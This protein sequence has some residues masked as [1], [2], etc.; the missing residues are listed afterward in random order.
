MRLQLRC[1]G[2][3]LNGQEDDVDNEADGDAEIEEGVCDH[4]VE[5]P[6]EPAPA[7]TTV[8]LQEEV[9]QEEAAQRTQALP[10]LLLLLP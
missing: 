1:H 2:I 7:A 9:S 6:F 4:G 8:P 10:L 5:L 3:M